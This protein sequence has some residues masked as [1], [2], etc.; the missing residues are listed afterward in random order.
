MNKKFL[1]N[2]IFL[3]FVNL[4]IKPFWILGIDVAVQNLVGDNSYG[5]YL[6]IS[7]FAY[8]FYILLDLGLTNFNNRNIAQNNQLL[9][10]HFVGISQAKILLTILYFIVIFVIGWI[11]GYRGEQLKLLA[12]VG[13]NQVLLSF[14]LYVRSNISALL[15]FKTDSMLSVLDRVLMILICSF[16]LWS[17]F[18]PKENF[19]IYTYIYAQTVSY[20]ITLIIAVIIVLRHTGKLT[21][22]INI[23]FV[24]MI[25]KKSLP[26]ALLVLLMSFYNRLEPVLIE[27]LLPEDIAASQAGVYAR[28]W[29]LFDAGNNISYLFSVILLPLFA[30]IIKEKEDLQGLVKQSFGIMLSM[31]CIIAVLC[32]FYSQNFMELMYPEQNNDEASIILKILMG[33]F[34][35]ISVTYIFGTLLTANG[36]LKQLN[37][38]AACGVVIN[39]ALNCM[40]IPHFQAV[41]AAFTSLC[42]QFTTCVIQFFIAKKIFNLR[43]GTSYWLRLIAFLSLITITVYLSTLLT[44]SWPISFAIAAIICILLAFI[45]KMLEYKEI[46]ELVMSSAKN[47]KK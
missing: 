40:F 22:R 1:K 37:I 34:V 32:I 47:M 19:N 18:F 15:L 6:A 46:K 13:F 43:L 33:S 27:R 21:I 41:G 42:V 17:G 39:I 28:A 25:I 20:V 31:T 9:S 24:I 12:I 44:T 45:T 26:Y 3:L 11:I 29:R 7:Q 8:L 14:I 35:S 16:M 5:L 4:L 2:I 23:P 10:K 30:A 36:N 38:V